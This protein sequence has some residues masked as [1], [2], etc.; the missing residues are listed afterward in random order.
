MEE[1]VNTFH[2]VVDTNQRNGGP[3]KKLPMAED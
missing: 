1:F 3:L 2:S